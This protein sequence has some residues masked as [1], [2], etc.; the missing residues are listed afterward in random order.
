MSDEITG[1]P[2]HIND[3]LLLLHRE[4]KSFSVFGWK[5]NLPHVY[6]NLEVHGG[7]P[8]PTKT[9]LNKE[10]VRI[11]AEFDANTYKAARSQDY[12][13][14]TDQLDMQYHDGVNGTTTWADAIA[15]VKTKYP[16]S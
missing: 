13:S 2:D 3:V 8:M 5:P 10:L 7:Y 11:Q 12:P 9:F 14:L 4:E 1:R 16:K 6:E 15:A